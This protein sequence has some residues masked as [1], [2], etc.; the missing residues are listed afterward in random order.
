[1]HTLV[2]VSSLKTADEIVKQLAEKV[3]FKGQ[4]SV[5]RLDNAEVL[6]PNAAATA[7]TTVGKGLT[8]LVL[9]VTT[10]VKDEI[11]QIVANKAPGMTRDII[12]E[13]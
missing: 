6:G 9:S 8:V 4:Y 2:V 13:F 3:N 12:G 11:G 7:M 5:T 1:M 10:A